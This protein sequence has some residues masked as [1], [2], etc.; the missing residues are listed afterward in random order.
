[1]NPVVP[2][3]WKIRPTLCSR[4]EKKKKSYLQYCN[5]RFTFKSHFNFSSLVNSFSYIALQVAQEIEAETKI[6]NDILSDLVNLL[7]EPLNS[8]NLKASRALGVP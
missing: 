6:Q 4:K 8:N 1:M 2:S 7:P 5:F 3:G